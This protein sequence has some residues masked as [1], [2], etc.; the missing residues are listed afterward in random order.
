MKIILRQETFEVHLL[1]DSTLGG[2]RDHVIHLAYFRNHCLS[3]GKLEG[4]H[5]I[6]LTL[7]DCVSEATWELLN[8]ENPDPLSLND[9]P[10]FR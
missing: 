1:H 10:E 8:T 2:K 5:K 9:L 7:S 6:F 3:T 4:L